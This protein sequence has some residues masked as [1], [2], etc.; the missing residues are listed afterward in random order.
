MDSGASRNFID[1][2]FVKQHKLTTQGT[3]PFSVE[4][5][6]GSKKE[7]NYAVN[8]NKLQIGKYTASRIITQALNLQ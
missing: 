4:L 8:I 2:K 7:I 6:D 1:E 5:A 3:K